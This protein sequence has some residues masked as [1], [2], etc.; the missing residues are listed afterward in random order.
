[1]LAR[2]SSLIGLSAHKLF[3]TSAKAVG[4]KL[5]VTLVP[6]SPGSGSRPLHCERV[7]LLR[8]GV[9]GEY[10]RADFCP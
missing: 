3:S 4:V 9:A 2:F 6:L 7:N 10:R 8:A 1:M 5:R